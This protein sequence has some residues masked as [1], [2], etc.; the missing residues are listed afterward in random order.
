MFDPGNS[1]WPFSS[2][3]SL[4]RVQ[5]FVIPWIA[6]HQASLPITSS[7][8]LL[9]F[10]SIESVMPPTISSS[11]V[12]FSSCFQSFPA[13][14]SFLFFFFSQLNLT[15][16]LFYLFFLNFYF[17]FIL[18]YNTVLVLPYIDMNP[19]WV[20][21]RSQTWTPLPPPSPQHPSGSSPFLWNIPQFLFEELLL[22]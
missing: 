1:H 8:S 11:V 6:A 18:L 17:Y 10:M 9:K 13:S 7:W 4:S 22:C 19:P 12:L 2:V 14:G 20:Y 16:I 3:Q 15:V 5:L 21:M